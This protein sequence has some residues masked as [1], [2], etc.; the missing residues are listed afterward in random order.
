[1]RT[2]HSW[3]VFSWNAVHNAL[4][5]YSY[6]YISFASNPKNTINVKK[7]KVV[8]RCTGWIPITACPWL[9]ALHQVQICS[10]V[11]SAITASK[12][13][14]LSE[15]R[16]HLLVWNIR[17]VLVVLAQLVFMQLL[18]VVC[19]VDFVVIFK[20]VAIPAPPSTGCS[21]QGNGDKRHK[22]HPPPPGPGQL[23]YFIKLGFYNRGLLVRNFRQ[24]AT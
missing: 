13:A 19:F 9:P 18:L 16:F 3:E 5:T 10:T 4:G 17:E 20:F 7:W 1:M 24:I 15:F 2:Y 14:Q 11:A 21:R 23:K 22:H 6:I 8:R 12:Y